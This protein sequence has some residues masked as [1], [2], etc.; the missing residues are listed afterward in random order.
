MYYHKGVQVGCHT[1]DCSDTLVWDFPSKREGKSQTKSENIETKL[2]ILSSF[3]RN[4]MK[5]SNKLPH[6]SILV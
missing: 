3:A 5:C 2:Y 1:A 4:K 6:R